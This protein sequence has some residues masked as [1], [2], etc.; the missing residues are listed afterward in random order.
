MNRLFAAG[1]ELGGDFEAALRYAR[2]RGLGPYRSAD[3]RPL[4]RRRDLAI[5]ARRGFGYAVALQVV[6]APNRE[7]NL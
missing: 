1:S 4:E 3:Q 7:E 2:R 6:D 5:L